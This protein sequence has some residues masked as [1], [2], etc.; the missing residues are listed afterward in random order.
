M[1]CL[2]ARSCRAQTSR[3]ISL[4][5]CGGRSAAMI[6]TPAPF[7]VPQV[8]QM[9]LEF[10]PAAARLGT[11]TCIIPGISINATKNQPHPEEHPKGAARITRNTD[12]VAWLAGPDVVD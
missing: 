3:G 5:I 10:C 6:E 1:M 11:H 4:A 8:I 2:S 7:P 12:A 9:I